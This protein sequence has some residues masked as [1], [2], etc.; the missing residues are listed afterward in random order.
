MFA[1]SPTEGPL[2]QGEVLSNVVEVHI[3]VDSLMNR[4]NEE[5]LELEEKVHPFALILSQDCDL[6]WDF[7]ARVE[8]PGGDKPVDPR[9]EN[10]RQAKL[11]PNV[12]LCELTTPDILR[13]R[14]DG[15]DILRRIKHNNDE[16][17]HY[18]DASGPAIDAAGEGLP[19]LVADFKRTFTVPTPEMYQRLRLGT[20][21]RAVLQPP[22][23]L[24]MSS[25]FGY[26]CQRVALPERVANEG[27][28]APALPAP[29]PAAQLPAAAGP[30]TRPE[31]R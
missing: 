9:E 15:S 5:G 28:A 27:V 17:Y 29:R 18:L 12:L 6:D 14:L 13:P 23:L 31:D 2:R 7:K 21:R 10:K 19:D 20:A 26:Y 24:H 25:R 30:P 8:T 3:R 4:G 22:Y 1:P 16:R 11:A